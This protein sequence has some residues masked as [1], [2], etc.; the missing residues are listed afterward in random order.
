MDKQRKLIRF[1]KIDG[2]AV[3]LAPER[4]LRVDEIVS[5]DSGDKLSEVYY[6]P[7]SSMQIGDRIVLLESASKVA[8][9]LSS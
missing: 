8:F 6:S 2:L 1:T 5:L 7:S 3:Y 9:D 4:V